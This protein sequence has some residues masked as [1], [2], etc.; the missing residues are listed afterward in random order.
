MGATFKHRRSKFARCKHPFCSDC[1]TRR[2]NKRA[3]RVER[4]NAKQA[5]R[6]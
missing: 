6:R 1:K 4:R 5:L 2:G 3:V